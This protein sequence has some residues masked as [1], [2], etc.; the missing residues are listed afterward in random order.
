MTLNTPSNNG[1]PHGEDWFDEW[2]DVYEIALPEIHLTRIC[3]DCGFQEDYRLQPDPED[4]F[5]RA[6]GELEEKR[7]EGKIADVSIHVDRDRSEGIN[8]YAY[9]TLERENGTGVEVVRE[10]PYYFYL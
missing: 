1:C 6:F 9:L 8:A 5:E 2:D 4:D 7:L 3:E 10:K